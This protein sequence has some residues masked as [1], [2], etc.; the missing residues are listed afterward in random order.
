ML[1][2]KNDNLHN[3]DGDQESKNTPEITSEQTENTT[4]EIKSEEIQAEE[5]Q[6]EEIQP[7]EVSPEK[8]A[9]ASENQ[10]A[11]D[12]I[13]SSNAEES[14]DSEDQTPTVNQ[15][16]PMLD[17]ET[18]SMQALV[19]EFE[20][21]LTNAKVSSVKNHLE[22]IRKEFTSKF[23]EFIEEKKEEYAAAH[24]GDTTDF[25]Y[26]LPLKQKF[27]GLL[28]QYKDKRNSYYKALEGKLT[29]NLSN[30]LEI[31]EE[32]KN[33]INPETNIPDL[34][35]Q[36]NEI[37]ER[38]RLAG[39]IPKDK[40]NHVWNN[41]HFHVENFYDYLHLDR[42]A[43]D[44]DFKHNLEQKQ[45]VIARAKELLDDTDLNR[46]FRELQLL[47]KLWKE[48][49][50]PVSREHREEIWN[51]FSAITKQIHDRREVFF[52]QQ[53][54]KEQENYAKKQEVIAKIADVAKNKV[55]THAEWQKQI[56]KIEALREE[57][58]AIGK[59][60][61]EKRD[62][63][64]GVF[65]EATKTFN[66]N[67]NAFYR[68]IKAEQQEN[69]NKKQALLDRAKELK[70]S[71]DFA[72]TTA[73]MKQIQE[74][75]KSIGHVPRKVSDSIWKEFKEACNFFFDRLHKKRGEENVG[76]TEAFQKKKEYLETMKAI[77]LSG[78]HKADLD[79]IKSHIDTWKSF[80][81][82]GYS[83]RHI[84]IKYNKI[85]DVLFSK[86]SL[87]KKETDAIRYNN[88]LSNLVDAD[89]AK[90]LNSERVF[91][92]RKIDEVQNEILQLENN[93]LFITGATDNNPFIIEVNK[94]IE[95]Q[96]LELISWKEKL[97]QLN[98]A[99]KKIQE[100]REEN[101]QK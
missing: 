95:R 27:D 61:T 10:K 1:E 97:S 17:Y 35:K 81:R 25:D 78:A 99:A 20:K 86:L 44:V 83:Q 87:S 51:E 71:E 30:R 77:E 96:K 73:V 31:I 33:I 34:F 74:E 45:K 55:E 11:I 28:N 32:L 37:R 13:D 68:N 5:V 90:K 93:V 91:L 94:N 8:L 6:P 58:F 46:V 70:D 56:Q 2:Q 9:V 89:D 12:D 21:L 19:D 69:L 101:T 23:N 22:E 16:V 18:L 48:E 63:L 52:Q 75:W 15:E 39:P 3:A 64:W 66:V 98:K 42:E 54:G 14:E 88:H 82:V 50:G 67:K 24:D 62:E 49:L 76:E 7:E 59:I 92:T 72:K 60:P 80:G 36:F 26:H 40:Y 57:F 84:E 100:Q 65:K 4:A 47:H 43:R 79:L 29:T 53:R 41:Y 38:W 85:L